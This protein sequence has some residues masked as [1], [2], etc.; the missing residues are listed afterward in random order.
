MRLTHF[1]NIRPICPRCRGNSNIIA[2]LE[3]Q[4]ITSEKGDVVFEGI[5]KCSNEEC[6][7]HYPIIDG[8]PIILPN[9]QQYLKDNFLFITARN[10]FSPVITS[11]LGDALGPGSRFNNTRHHVSS[12]G[13]DHYGD[14]ITMPDVTTAAGTDMPGNAL[15]CLEAGL[16]LLPGEPV[17]PALDIGCALGRTTFELAEQHNSLALGCDI[18]F[19]TLRIAQEILHQGKIRFPL[20]HLGLVYHQT[21]YEVVFDNRDKVDFWICNALSMPFRQET[22]AFVAALNVF[23]VSAMPRDLLLSIRNVLQTNGRAIITTPYDWT[24]GVP[25]EK[26][27][28]GHAQHLTHG[29]NS[30]QMMRDLLTP[31]MKGKIPNLQLVGEITHHPWHVRVHSRRTAVYDTHILA[32]EKT[33]HR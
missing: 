4:Q 19:W 20:K 1:E 15:R 12:Y 3:L 26:W 21:E 14:K 9:L 23:D 24:T 27:L 17:S 33:L 6:Q 7:M 5:L 28:G 29:G 10:D 31:G 13:W 32:C 18:S 16:D 22:F 8:I 30:E 25:T 11:L 2:P